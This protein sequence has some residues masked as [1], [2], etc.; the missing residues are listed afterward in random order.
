MDRFSAMLLLVSLLNYPSI[1]IA[2]DGWV[3]KK[4]EDGIRV[5][6]RLTPE[7]SFRE[8][9]G[10]AEFKTSLNSIVSL[11]EDT[12]A[13]KEWIYKCIKEEKLPNSNSPSECYKYSL[14]EGFPYSDRDSIVHIIRNQDP[15]IK[16]VTFKRTGIPDFIPEKPDIVRVPKVRGSWRLIPKG[17]GVVQVIFQ[18][19]SDP[20]G[21]IPPYL[22]NLM[23]TEVPF[24]TLLGMKRMISKPKYRDAKG[25]VDEYKEDR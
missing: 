10:I 22:A 3:L 23:V 20:R 6:T 11:L 7:S 16:T 14:S 25:L 17:N 1:S 21:N 13:C 9:K 5:F 18:T 4:K 8:F 24:E 12:G 15:K 2:E 19:L